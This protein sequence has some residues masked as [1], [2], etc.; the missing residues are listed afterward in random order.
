MSGLNQFVKRSF[1][2]LG[3]QLRRIPAQ[4]PCHLYSFP[5][6]RAILA[7]RA[8][9]VILD[10]GAN[11]G[12]SVTRY[13]WLFPEAVIH[14]FEPVPEAFEELRRRAADDVNAHVWPLAVSDVT[15]TVRFNSNRMSDTSS[16][17]ATRA[18]QADDIYLGTQAVLEV[19]STTLDEFCS[20]HNIRRVAILKLDVQGGEALVLRGARQLLQRQALD[21]I[22]TEVWFDAPYVGAPHFC[23]I[24]TT[25]RSYGYQLYGL[26]W[27]P[28]QSG[29]HPVF[30]ADAIYLNRSF[31]G[32]LDPHCSKVDR[33]FAASFVDVFGE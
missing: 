12:Q 33:H 5:D 4:Y 16:L 19:A 26:Y 3:F 9:D 18:D 32:Q 7:D 24:D 27:G 23:E 6:Q 11:I 2:K 29:N 17:L 1:R 13:R 25:L 28:H 15:G 21:L 20:A 30:T 22:L 14:S 10:V 31:V 8:V